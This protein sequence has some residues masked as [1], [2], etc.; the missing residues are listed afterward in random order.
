MKKYIQLKVILISLGFVLANPVGTVVFKLLLFFG[1]H[2]FNSIPL[3]R[4]FL[5]F[6][7]GGL[8]GYFAVKINDSWIS[9]HYE[10]NS[11][12]TYNKYTFI[13]NIFLPTVIVLTNFYYAH[14]WVFTLGLSADWS[15]YIV[16]IISYLMFVISCFWNIEKK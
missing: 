13:N 14:I 9:S 11:T 15:N 10:R 6:I 2:E 3:V 5:P 1:D 16:V 12:F 7:H 8:I 4:A